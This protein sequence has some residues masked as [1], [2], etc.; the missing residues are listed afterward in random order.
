M[1]IK[2]LFTFLTRWEQVC[3]IEESCKGATVGIDLFWFLY[4][5]RGNTE[6]LKA[7]LAPFMTH[8]KTVH[9]VIDGKVMTDERKT[10]VKERRDQ[11]QETIDIIDEIRSAPALEER[12]QQ[13]LDRYVEQLKRKAWKPSREYIDQIKQILIDQGAI[14]HEAKGEA[15]E[16]LM[17]L[18]QAGIIERIVTND[19]DLIA[20]G[21][22]TV[23]RP[24]KTPQTVKQ[25]SKSHMIQQMGFT[26][27]QWEDFMYMCQHVEPLVA[28]S[29]IRVYGTREEAVARL[30]HLAGATD[31]CDR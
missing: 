6:A 19:S 4:Q 17:E 27:Q 25:L 12:D 31:Q 23:L 2:G 13:I 15:D 30:T 22:E 10:E 28:Y 11:R 3:T 29:M 9:I 1:G 26:I 16:A 7:S 21:G 8:S 24:H 18:E 14:I 20:L 5:S